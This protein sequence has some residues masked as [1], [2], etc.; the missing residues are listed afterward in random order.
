[1]ANA[2]SYLFSPMGS[3]L[4][5]EPATCSSP[6]GLA[7]QRRQAALCPRLRHL[8]CA[9]RTESLCL[10]DGPQLPLVLPPGAALWATEPVGQ[11]LVPPKATPK[12]GSVV[13]PKWL[14]RG[15]SALTS[16]SKLPICRWLSK[17][18]HK[19]FLLRQKRWYTSYIL[20]KEPP[21][22]PR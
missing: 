1:M 17:V 18:V 11:P 10:A 16:W 13:L 2:R 15:F 19:G 3:L 7:H 22:H 4:R 9:I 12:T 14:T 6:G 8:S 21:P 5:P 20:A